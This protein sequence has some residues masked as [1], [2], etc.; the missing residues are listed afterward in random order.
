MSFQQFVGNVSDTSTKTCID[1][2]SRSLGIFRMVYGHSSPTNS[3]P[4]V[5][6][7]RHC[8]IHMIRPWMVIVDFYLPMLCVVHVLI[9]CGTC[10]I[11][12]SF[13]WCRVYIDSFPTEMMALVSI[14]L[15]LRFY[16]HTL[17]VKIL[18]R[19]PFTVHFH[20][21]LRRHVSKYIAMRH[22]YTP[23]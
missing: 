13:V 4:V 17:D 20:L 3:L 22:R 12:P 14:P 23:W 19:V 6:S 11:F 10:S 21:S 1:C 5:S 8:T 7:I 2:K 16:L 18:M 9:Y 15:L